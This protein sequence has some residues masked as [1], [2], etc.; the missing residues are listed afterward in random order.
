MIYFDMPHNYVTFVGSVT[1]G[2]A[3]EKWSFPAFSV[4]H[5]G[6]GQVVLA[7]LRVFP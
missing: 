6:F 3:G 4:L 2:V 5:R 1:V 7:S